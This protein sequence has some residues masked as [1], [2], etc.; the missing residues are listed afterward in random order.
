MFCFTVFAFAQ[1]QV[2][3][4]TGVTGVTGPTGTT[5]AKY[6]TQEDATGDIGIG[7]VAPG[8]TGCTG[9]TGISSI[10]GVG[11]YT[12]TSSHNHAVFAAANLTGTS[13]STLAP[14]NTPFTMLAVRLDPNPANM[15]NSGT[16]DFSVDYNGQCA[17]GA[18]AFIFNNVSTSSGYSGTL[19]GVTDPNNSSTTPLFSV[20]TNTHFLGINLAAMTVDWRGYTSLGG[21]FTDATPNPAHLFLTDPNIF[22]G[23]PLFDVQTGGGS[24]SL[25]IPANGYV[26]IGTATPA[27]PLDV[28]G[29]AN[30][31]GSATIGNTM[32][33]GSHTTNSDQGTLT[34]DAVGIGSYGYSTIIQVSDPTVKAFAI[35]QQCQT[36][37]CTGTTDQFV[38]FA[39]GHTIIGGKQPVTS[40]YTPFLLAVN[41]N[42][43]AQQVQVETS[44]WADFV[45]DKGYKLPTLYSLEAYISHNK[46]LPDVPSECD[47]IDKGVNLGEM[48][49]VLLQKVEELTLYLI[50]QQKEIDALKNK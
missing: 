49:K 42:V 35:N 28:V 45:F 19:L 39:D 23:D 7:I 33:I 18:P 6:V 24:Q 16:L 9:Y 46:H 17:I 30:V 44:D 22:G 31:S 36:T 21:Y 43:V 38:V 50:Q 12:N 15:L 37:G 29:N 41:G 2:S 11:N 3:L 1:A 14:G 47:A 25:F 10:L 34:I 20:A 27:Y 4:L 48:N 5:G 13:G 40:A 8:C 26:G 32:T